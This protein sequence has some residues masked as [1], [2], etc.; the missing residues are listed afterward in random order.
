MMHSFSA[1][2]VALW[3]IFVSVSVYGNSLLPSGPV[4]LPH[5]DGVIPAVIQWWYFTGFLT[6]S[7]NNLYG[8]EICFFLGESMTQVAHVAVSDVNA[9]KFTFNSVE[10]VFSDPQRLESRYNF[11]GGSVADGNLVTGFGGDGDD[12]LFAQVGGLSGYTLDLKITN[13]KPPAVHYNGGPHKY[14]PKSGGGWTYYYSRPSMSV[15]G[16]IT[17]PDNTDAQIAVSGDAWFD[18]Q[19]GDL[20]RVSVE[21]GWQWF[22]IS[23]DDDTQIML[24]F[25]VAVQS[26]DYDL[27]KIEMGSVTNSNGVTTP[28]TVE[29]TS[30]KVLDYWTSPRTNCKYPSGWEVTVRGEGTFTIQPMI[31]DQELGPSGEG[32]PWVTPIYWE[33]ANA[34]TGAKN[35]KAYVELN[36]Y[37]PRHAKSELN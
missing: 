29:E 12:T 32:E 35:G 27:D 8:F 24:F 31:K 18:R 1:I 28:L 34:V 20:I 2:V 13:I 33:G 14:S 21:G 4:S 23:L 5:D 6:S 9:N 16:Q 7:D 15:K 37:C 11:T 3:L 26:S 25:T 17:L 19:Y 30:I 10:K 22:A 36:G